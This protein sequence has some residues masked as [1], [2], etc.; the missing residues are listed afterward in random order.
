MR[1][2]KVKKLYEGK[3]SL[4]DY[5]VDEAI[6][7]KEGIL[8]QLT[9]GGMI[10]TMYLSPEDLALKGKTSDLVLRSK[11]GE[12]VYGLIDYKWKV[13]STPMNLFNGGKN[14]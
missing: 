5:I 10:G 13:N 2:V 1:K 6:K 3:I 9:A 7:N 4:R 11:W 12:R 8:V 14:G